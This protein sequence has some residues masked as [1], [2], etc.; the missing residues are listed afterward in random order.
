MKSENRK[1]ML[2][3]FREWKNNDRKGPSEASREAQK[4]EFTTDTE[5]PKNPTKA[6]VF[7]DF[8]AKLKAQN[9]ISH[10]K[11]GSLVFIGKR[12][13][14][15]QANKFDDTFYLCR[16][17]NGNFE[18]I[19]SYPI[20]TDPGTYYLQHPMRPEGCAIME[21]GIYVDAYARGLHF[22]REALVQVGK[23]KVYRDNDKDNILDMD[24]ETLQEGLFAINIHEQF[25]V[26]DVIG[27]DSAAC[28]VFFKKADLQR[29]LKIVDASGQKR[30]TLIL[31]E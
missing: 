16:A 20:T 2:E 17:K 7:T 29:V 5:K 9:P 15:R 30:F 1:T 3:Q 24:P 21:E 27:A 26:D 18:I 14:E 23:I 6:A 8:S 13:P 10:C 25:Q 22:K 12:S 31:T 28:W 4:P 19:D 11:E